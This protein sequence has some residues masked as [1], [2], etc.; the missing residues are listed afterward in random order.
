M[1]VVAVLAVVGMSAWRQGLARTSAHIGRQVYELQVAVTPAERTTGLSGRRSVADNQ[2]MLFVFARPAAQCMWM[3][4]MFVPLDMLWLDHDKRIVHLE[5][6][7]SPGTY[8]KEF[9]SPQPAQYV[10]EVPA[11]QAVQAGSTD[12]LQVTF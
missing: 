7:V 11:G 2:G 12:G 8:P 1:L 5:T 9:C 6:D 3:K 4:D 10:I